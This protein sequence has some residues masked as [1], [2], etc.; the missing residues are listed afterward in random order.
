M[1]EVKEGVIVTKNNGTTLLTYTKERWEKYGKDLKAEGY[2]KATK[3]EIEAK[4]KTES[5]PTT[6]ES[7]KAS[8]I[9]NSNKNK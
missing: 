2:R 5:V 3:K 9:D 1:P 8:N 6:K 4:Y 7:N